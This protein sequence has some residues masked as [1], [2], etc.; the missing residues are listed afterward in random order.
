[1][2]GDIDL[3]LK[4]PEDSY[5]PFALTVALSAFFIALLLHWWW[6]AAAGGLLTIGAIMVWLWP[7]RELGQTADADHG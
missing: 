3:I 6:L 4:M 7:E 5:A 2:D 1:L